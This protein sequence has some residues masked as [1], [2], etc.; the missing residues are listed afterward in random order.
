MKTILIYFLSV[1]FLASCATRGYQ[2]VSSMEEL[3]SK[4]ECEK[5]KDW[6]TDSEAKMGTAFVAGLLG[7]L[8]I[9][10]PVALAVASIPDEKNITM[11]EVADRVASKTHA[12][13]T[14]QFKSYWDS[15]GSWEY[16]VT[17]IP[18]D[19]VADDTGLRPIG[20]VYLRHYEGERKLYCEIR[21]VQKKSEK[22]YWNW[23]FQL[24][25][26]DEQGDIVYALNNKL[27]L[28]EPVL[29]QRDYNDRWLHFT[30]VDEAAGGANITKGE[31]EIFAEVTEHFLKNGYPLEVMKCPLGDKDCGRPE[32][33][34][35][36][37]TQETSQLPESARGTL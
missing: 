17:G 25:K 4:A 27:K 10:L 1:C 20:L 35:P 13:P 18:A 8:I 34:Q 24:L 2:P 9:G 3:S 14:K 26:R 21:L 23:R 28:R 33:S 19:R 6:V 32:T 29:V 16:A 30:F 12:L 36:D 15:A 11:S 22:E 7:G 37:A 31:E 5:S